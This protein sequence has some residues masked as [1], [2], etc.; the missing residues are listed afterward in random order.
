MI[1]RCRSGAVTLAFVIFVI[2]VAHA[3]D[4]AP[5]SATATPLRVLFIGNSLT[6]TNNLPG[7]VAGLS[8][9]SEAA[10]R[11]EVGEA[12]YPNWSLWMHWASGKALK[13]MRSEHWDF[14]V[15][16][17][18]DVDD[19]KVIELFDA[20]VRK[21]GARTILIVMFPSLGKRHPPD[22]YERQEQTASSLGILS[23]P[24][25]P[26]WKL[27]AEAGISQ[28][29]FYDL[30][31]SHPS[32]VGTYLWACVIYSVITGM[33]P[34]GLRPQWGQSAGGPDIAAL[35]SVAWRA[36]QAVPRPAAAASSA[37]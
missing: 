17:P 30:D 1:G 26:A 6:Y 2:G 33:S 21:I 25:G 22:Y 19:R 35:N 24:V 3:Q 32:F 20:E 31:G 34:E 8:L 23:A 36:V 12:T 11:I 9:Q 28:S 16:Q 18:R 14:V 10:R 13:I 15:L 29:T 27:A 5:P 4:A 7:A 37:N